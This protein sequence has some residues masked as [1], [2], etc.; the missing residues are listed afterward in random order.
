VIKNFEIVGLQLQAAYGAMLP[1][2][3][4]SIVNRELDEGIW[5]D[6]YELAVTPKELSLDESNELLRIILTANP[7]CKI[8]IEVLSGVVE[9]ELPQ[10]TFARLTWLVAEDATFVI[11]DSLRVARFKGS[12][13][14]W[15]T[16]RISYDGI[17]LIEVANEEVH[18]LCWHLS[19]SYEPDEPFRLDLENGTILTGTIIE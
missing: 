10:G 8:N 1:T 15:C 18:G 16:P 4:K 7:E 6:G 5:L 13:M 11:T 19:K 14:M 9:K 17:K 3:V 2:M 12:S